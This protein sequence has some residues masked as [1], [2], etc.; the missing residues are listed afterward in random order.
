[1]QLQRSEEEGGL[2]VAAL[3]GSGVQPLGSKAQRDLLSCGPW[4]STRST[5]SLRGPRES[6]K[7]ERVQLSLTQASLTPLFSPQATLQGAPYY[8]SPAP[9][10]LTRPQALMELN[11][12]PAAHLSRKGPN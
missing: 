12:L 10:P 6:G 9:A 1:M 3:L 2:T 8:S 11:L 4:I 7:S 5:S